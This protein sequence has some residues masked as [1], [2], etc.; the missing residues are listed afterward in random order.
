MGGR[1]AHPGS[2]CEGNERRWSVLHEPSV[3]GMEGEKQD[4]RGV[5][6]RLGA[7]AVRPA[8][9]RQAVPHHWTRLVW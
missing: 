1:G 8:G 7:A 6:P 4:A 3:E 5:V 2:L 9:L